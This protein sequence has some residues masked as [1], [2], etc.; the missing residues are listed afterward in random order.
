MPIV[1]YIIWVGTSL[2]ALLFAANWCLPQS[3]REARET[4]DKPVIRIASVQH[5]PESILIDTSQPT[6]VPPPSPVENEIPAPPPSTSPLQSFASV[7]PPQ[8]RVGVVNKKRTN[9]KGQEKVVTRRSPPAITHMAT[10]SPA[11]TP[12]SP[13]QLSLLDMVSGMGKRLFSLR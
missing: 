12:A 9:P 10:G 2:L 1:R 13:T 8:V 11:A 5:P 3:T 6:I 4:V 7:E